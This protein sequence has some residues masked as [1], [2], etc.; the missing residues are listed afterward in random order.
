MAQSHCTSCDHGVRNFYTSASSSDSDDALNNGQ[1]A[2][3]VQC[4]TPADLC[5]CESDGTCCP[6]SA[7]P[8]QQVQLTPYC[9]NGACFMYAS[10]GGDDTAA[11]VCAGTT[12]TVASQTSLNVNDGTHLKADA[13]SCNGCDSIRNDKCLSPVIDGGAPF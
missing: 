12:V 13:V 10:L 8:P 9:E 3:V 7:T 1:A 4:D 5:I 2:T 6:A 11:V